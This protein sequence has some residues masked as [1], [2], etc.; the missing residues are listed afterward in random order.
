QALQKI[1]HEITELNVAFKSAIRN[2]GREFQKYRRDDLIVHS[3]EEPGSLMSTLKTLGPKTIAFYT[4]ITKS[5][6][7]LI[8]G[9]SEIEK[10]D[11]FSIS[12]K[13]LNKLIG[14]FRDSLQ[15]PKSNPVPLAHRLYNIL[16]RPFEHDI[17]IIHPTTILWYLD[18]TLKYLPV[19]ALFDGN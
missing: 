4:L 6:F 14:E 10:A 2:I 19:S 12:S 9:T 7:Y 17:S 8:L 5:K 16:L 18:G 13:A 15:N 3:I 11:S 1:N